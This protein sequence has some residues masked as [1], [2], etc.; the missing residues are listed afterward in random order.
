[1][2]TQKSKTRQVCTLLTGS[3]QAR[4]LRKRCGH[5]PAEPVAVSAQLAALV[6]PQQRYGYDRIAWVGLA[7][8]QQHRCAR[9]RPSSSLTT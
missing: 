3:I 5:C 8:Y 4:E 2:Q 1:M 9:N 7:R 6:P